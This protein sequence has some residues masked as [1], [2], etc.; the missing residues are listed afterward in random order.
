MV[1]LGTI[2]I[3]MI[4]TT[5]IPPDKAKPMVWIGFIGTNTREMKP[6]IVVSADKRTAL[7]VELMASDIFSLGEPLASA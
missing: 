5:T 1:R 3:V 7:P 4:Y 6:M 2:S